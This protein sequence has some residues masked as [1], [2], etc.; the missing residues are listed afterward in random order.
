MWIIGPVK[1][2]LSGP[3]CFIGSLIV[4]VCFVGTAVLLEEILLNS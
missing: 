1:L 3:G 4:A 2:G